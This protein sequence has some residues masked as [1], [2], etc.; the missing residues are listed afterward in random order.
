MPS[1]ILFSVSLILFPHVSLLLLYKNMFFSGKLS[2][3]QENSGNDLKN[4]KTKFGEGI[5]TTF[6]RQ[7]PRLPSRATK[8][9]ENKD[10]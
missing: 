2:E 5:P 6:V 3:K 4:S 8:S 7:S 10:Q 1:F 9:K